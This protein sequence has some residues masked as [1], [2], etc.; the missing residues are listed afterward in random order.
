MKLK[1]NLII[2]VVVLALLGGMLY[3]LLRPT[4][5]EGPVDDTPQSEEVSV[6]QVEDLQRITLENADLFMTIENA[7]GTWVLQRNPA[8]KMN[9]N[10]ITSLTT[11]VSDLKAQRLMT[12]APENLADYGLDAPT[13]T[14]T[15]EGADGT[16][17][18]IY[19]GSP[20]LDKTAYYFKTNRSDSVYTMNAIDCGL[21]FSR[22]TAFRSTV[23]FDRDNEALTEILVKGGH[24][25]H[26]VKRT[27]DDS[28]FSVSQWAMQ[29]PY[30]ANTALME[31]YNN[32]QLKAA[33]LIAYD[34]I[35]GADP[36]AYGFAAPRYTVTLTDSE[37]TRF[38]V[39]GDGPE[40]YVYVMLEGDN[41]IYVVD[42]AGL[43]YLSA[44]PL[45]IMDKHTALFYVDDVQRL[46]LQTPEKTIA[47]RIERMQQDDGE[48][49]E[50]VYV[51]DKLVETEDFRSAYQT[52]MK[53]QFDD[54]LTQ[55]GSAPEVTVTFD[56]NDGATYAVEFYPSDAMNYCMQSPNAKD[57]SVKR[58][59][60]DKVIS[61][62]EKLLSE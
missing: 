25:Y 19:L 36:A 54:Y 49:A 11:V 55:R 3:L 40:G 4:P 8:A 31:F 13:V 58:K 5:Q 22:I 51:N 59:Y 18:A 17:Y 32:V 28:T 16:Q 45:T 38:Y 39:G 48:Q 43:A 2:L 10:A 37:T 56:F 60:V 35:D 14:V 20:V 21:L 26:F 6:W 57:F 42:S 50:L 47:V 30:V 12:D 23:L 61:E 62:F 33:S 52:L 7:G 27:Q 46:T 15:A 34:F 9:R 44:D 53:V 29:S 41:T 1:R 24:N